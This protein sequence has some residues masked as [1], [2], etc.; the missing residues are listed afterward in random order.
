MHVKQI[1]VRTLELHKS[2]SMIISLI[3]DARLE[4][5]LV[6]SLG[7]LGRGEKFGRNSFLLQC[8][9]L[10]FLTKENLVVYT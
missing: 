6:L 3:T 7:R 9:H 1:N 4:I 2:S 10:V 5:H 8:T